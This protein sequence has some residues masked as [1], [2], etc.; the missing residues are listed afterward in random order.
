[1]LYGRSHTHKNHFHLPVVAALDDEKA[2]RMD[3]P[4]VPAAAAAVAAA[5]AGALV[6]AYAR[7]DF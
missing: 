4:M 1:M 2:Y 6:P 5:V 7:M 3:E